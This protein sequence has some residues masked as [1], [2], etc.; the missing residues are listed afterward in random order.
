[1]CRHFFGEVCL[2]CTSDEIDT[3]PRLS[4]SSHEKFVGFK[5]TQK[6]MYA[7]KILRA[8]CIHIF[9]NLG[10]TARAS[11]F[12]RLHDHTDTHHSR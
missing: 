7:Y 12:P 8:V 2:N 4:K 11:S 5:Y 9:L 10:A 3:T 6:I 1:M